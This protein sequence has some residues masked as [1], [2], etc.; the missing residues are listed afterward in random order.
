VE[1]GVPQGSPVS[2]V[3]FEINTSQ[4]IKWVQEYVSAEGLSF[5][6]DLGWVATGRDVNQVIPILEKYAAKTIV[7]RHGPADE[8]YSSIPQKRKRHYSL[9]DEATKN[10]SG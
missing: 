8:G 6:D 2:L 5:V 1:A 10:T 9:A 3:L 7:W 4:W